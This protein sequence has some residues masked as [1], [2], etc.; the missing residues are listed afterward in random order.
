MKTKNHVAVIF[1]FSFILSSCKD[2]RDV[3]I[4]E[5]IPEKTLIENGDRHPEFLEFYGKVMYSYDKISNLPITEKS[6]HKNITYLSL[7]NAMSKIDKDFIDRESGKKTKQSA[8]EKKWEKLF[9]DCEKR[10]DDM[11]N[12][13]RDG[14]FTEAPGHLI[15]YWA[16]IN[17]NGA[18]DEAIRELIDKDYIDKED[19]IFKSR[20]PNE[21][22]FYKATH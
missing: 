6:K 17:A 19:F 8:L 14:R 1:I 10:L 7:F 12:Y 20:F 11:S 13:Y 15:R 21:Y 4:F 2:Y 18:K 9:G 5:K 22:E 3:S 16:R